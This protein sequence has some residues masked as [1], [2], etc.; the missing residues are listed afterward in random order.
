MEDVVTA[1]YPVGICD[2]TNNMPV[3]RRGVTATHPSLDW[4]GRP[5]FLIDAACFVGSSG[6]P[7]FLFNL[8]SYPVKSGRM[9]TGSRAKLLGVLYQVINYTVEGKIRPEA[10][11][12]STGL[13]AASPIPLNLG[14]V[15]KSEKLREF[16]V[17]FEEQLVK[18]P[19]LGFAPYYR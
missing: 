2:D 4:N 12:T 5:E 13:V 11:P 7:V 16:E 17:L 14:V 15:I 1:G 19:E 9:V 6:S 8:G 18:F 10:I 3:L